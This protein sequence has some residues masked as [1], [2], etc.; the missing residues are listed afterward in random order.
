MAK[1]TKTKAAKKST[2]KNANRKTYVAIVLDRS[3]SMSS[4]HKETV[5]GIN[6]QF[7]AIK[8]TAKKAGG[9]TF[10]SLIQFD[11]VIETRIDSVTPDKLIEWAITD[12]A[13]RGGTALYDGI[14]A[15]MNHLKAKPMTDDT[16]YLVC[17][18]SDGCETSS[19][20]VTQPIMTAEIK[21]L[22]D[23]G[24]WVF[25]YLMANVDI[26]QAQATFA[27]SPGNIA[28]YN[29]TSAGANVT[30]TAN[31]VSIGNY[32]TTRGLV[33]NASGMSGSYTAYD[34]ATKVKLSSTT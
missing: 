24:N 11:T 32:M 9:E 20:E 21:K 3:G 14:W 31:A 8:K 5:D 25:T 23:Q 19:R 34:T 12:F 13:P 18:I 17:V 6:K 10:V 27:A 30:Y 1:P 28:I 7:E 33:S 2:K 26:R 4:I 29:S 16:A 15:A 22:Q